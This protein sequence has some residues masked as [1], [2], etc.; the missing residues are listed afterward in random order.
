MNRYEGFVDNM[1]VV[2]FGPLGWRRFGDEDLELRGSQ[3]S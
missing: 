1:T 2:Y 3:N